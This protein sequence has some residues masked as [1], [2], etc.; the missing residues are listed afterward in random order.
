MEVETGGSQLDFLPLAAH[1]LL[2][3]SLSSPQITPFPRLCTLP[4][5]G[6][7]EHVHAVV[8]V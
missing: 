8:S 3:S 6:E 4:P 5:K 1:R 2:R 7:E